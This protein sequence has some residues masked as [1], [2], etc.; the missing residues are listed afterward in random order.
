MNEK[1]KKRI[2]G[3]EVVEDKFRIYPNVKIEVPIR[4]DSKSA[5]YDMRTPVD[6]RLK[7]NERKI[8]FTD[9]KAYMNDNEVLDVY[10]RSSIGV[11]RGIHLSNGTGIIDASAYDNGENDGNIGLSLWNTNDYDVNIKAGER[12]CQGIFKTYLIADHDEYLETE[13][14]GIFGSSGEI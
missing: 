14:R 11:K 6:I 5:G 7:P 1:K 13:R 8:I 2:R 9:L 10:V 3:F 4:G 12:I